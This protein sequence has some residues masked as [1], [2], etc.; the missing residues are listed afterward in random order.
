MFK[1]FAYPLEKLK[2]EGQH[3]F[4]LGHLYEGCR[5]ASLVVG[6]LDEIFPNRPDAN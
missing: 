4:P 3:V 1:A 2:Y 5:E 6:N